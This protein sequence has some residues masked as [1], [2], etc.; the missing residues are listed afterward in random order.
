MNS[1][2]QV[3]NQFKKSRQAVYVALKKKKFSC[4]N[5]EGEWK[6]SLDDYISYLNSRYDRTFSKRN[7]GSLVFD[8]SQG[9]YSA[10]EAAHYLNL[11]LQKIYYYLR[12]GMIPSRRYKSAWLIH[13][14]DLNNC[15]NLGMI[16]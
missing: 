5:E 8:K 13:I 14:D 2:T 11:G 16:A 4:F 9:F 3:A 7:D 10:K 1:I 15:K 6:I 12:R